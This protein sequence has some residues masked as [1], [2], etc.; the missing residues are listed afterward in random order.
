MRITMLS[1]AIVASV[2]ALQLHAATC[3]WKDDMTKE[4]IAA[5]RDQPAQGQEA[6]D[7]ERSSKAAEQAANR[8]RDEQALSERRMR[9]ERQREAERERIASIPIE[10][11]VG[12]SAQA[13]AELR[14]RNYERIAEYQ[15]AHPLGSGGS[16]A[17]YDLRWGYW[18]SCT[19]NRTT[20][21][22]GVHEQWVCGDRRYVYVDD[23]IV[24][25]VQQ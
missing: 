4:E 21:A 15:K 5:C 16:S 8:H 3:V 25:A 13:F 10:P 9:E 1:V 14:Q 23:G 20:T 11:S 22:R 19:V 7:R 6:D 24:T 18:D 2:S 12:M 17:G